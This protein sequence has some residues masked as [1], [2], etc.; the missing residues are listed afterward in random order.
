MRS[1]KDFQAR[2]AAQCRRIT[3]RWRPESPFGEKSNRAWR[4]LGRAR[5][6]W[7]GPLFSQ[8]SRSAQVLR[9]HRNFTVLPLIFRPITSGRGGKQGHSGEDS[10]LSSFDL[11]RYGGEGKTASSSLRYPS[12]GAPNPSRWPL[13][14]CHAR[15]NFRLRSP[16]SDLNS[17][18]G[19]RCE[20]AQQRFP[21]EFP[22]AC[23]PA[24][25]AVPTFAAKPEIE[26]P[27]PPDPPGRA[28]T[29]SFR[30]TAGWSGRA[31]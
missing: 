12:W 10:R 4:G 18:L 23:G 24:I 9:K 13:S 11:R 14:A 20:T 29:P 27:A 8:A 16:D 2:P 28:S 26:T 21:E 22:R 17:R 15:K 30:R 3:S 1:A 6:W 31:G 19:L 7:W 25:P 5:T